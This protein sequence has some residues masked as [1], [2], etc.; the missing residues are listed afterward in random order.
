[1]V[2]QSK[3]DGYFK[4]LASKTIK[5]AIVSTA[6]DL[7]DAESQTDELGNIDKFN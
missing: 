7:V 2:P 1:M 5:T 3:Q 6:D 4:K